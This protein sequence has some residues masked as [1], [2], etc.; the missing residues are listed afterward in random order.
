MSEVAVQQTEIIADVRDWLE[1]FIIRFNLCPFAKRE[2][3]KN[4]VRF[5][6]SSAVSPE[7][8]L[9]ALL[10]ELQLLDSDSEIETT[11]LIH[12]D[13]LQQFEDYNQFLDLADELINQEGYEGI[14]QVASFHPQY[15]FAETEDEAEDYSNRSPYPLLHILRESSVASQV[16]S[17]LDIDRIPDRNI[18]LLR[19]LGVA[20]LQ[21]ILQQPS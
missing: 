8:L 16:A 5:T 4:R 3:A 14:F 7:Q 21:S 18:R 12:P 10:E 1:S 19:S 15:R 9:T 13:V 20:K 17:Y 2:L 6:V 11:L